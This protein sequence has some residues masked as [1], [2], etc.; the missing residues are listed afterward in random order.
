ML[1]HLRKFICL[2][3]Y[4]FQFENKVYGSASKIGGSHLDSLYDQYAG[5]FFNS[6]LY[7]FKAKVLEGDA[8]SGNS[9]T[10][11]PGI[12]LVTTPEDC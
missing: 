2:G 6:D 5:Q 9:R 7:N 3:F 8:I 1:R 11:I 12:T 10:H 4:H